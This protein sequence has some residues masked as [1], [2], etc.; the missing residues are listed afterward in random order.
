[1]ASDEEQQQEQGQ[2]G[3]QGQC[4]FSKQTQRTEAARGAVR[5]PFKPS[6]ICQLKA[7]A[8]SAGGGGRVIWSAKV[9]NGAVIQVSDAD[10]KAAFNGKQ[11]PTF[12]AHCKI[13]LGVW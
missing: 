7:E 2:A 3:G 1:M 13:K 4:P 6:S 8:S 5:L 12:L 9:A 11:G 10:V